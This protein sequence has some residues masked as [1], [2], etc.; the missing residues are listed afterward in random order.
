M[1]PTS[2]M[3]PPPLISYG[4]PRGIESPRGSTNVTVT[5]TSPRLMYRVRYIS[6]TEVC[7]FDLKFKNPL[8]IFVEFLFEVCFF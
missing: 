1:I 3:L 6:E 8:C 5:S 2:F 7:N 4:R